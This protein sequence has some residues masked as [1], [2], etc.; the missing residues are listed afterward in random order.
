MITRRGLSNLILLSLEKMV[1]GYIS[2]EDFNANYYKYLYQYPKPVKKSNLSLT[3]K[4][5][6]EGGLIELISDEQLL[7]RL[8]DKGKE[9]ALW[10]K[11]KFDDE[12]W[13][14]KWRLVMFDIPEKRRQARDLLRSKLKQW[15]FMHW[16]KSVWASKKNCVKPMRNFI[17]QVGIGDW[18]KVLESDNVA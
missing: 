2:F 3:L 15:G 13:D 11:I 1:D 9:Q 6:R 4:R 5:L 7:L 8:T 10:A 17:K 16:Q 12:K 14:G 18:V